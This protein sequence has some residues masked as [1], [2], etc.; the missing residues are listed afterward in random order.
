MS[1]GAA[2]TVDGKMRDALAH[3]IAGADWSAIQ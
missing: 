2:D 3:G 1:G